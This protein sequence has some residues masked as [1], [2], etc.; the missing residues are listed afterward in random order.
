MRTQPPDPFW[1][2]VD[3]WSDPEACWRWIGPDTA[4]GYGVWRPGDGSH[5]A[6]RYAWEQLVG[7]VPDGLELHHK[8]ENPGC[9]NPHHLEP[10]THKEHQA[11]HP[12]KRPP[13]PGP[14]FAAHGIEFMGVTDIQREFRVSRQAVVMWRQRPD[15][16][17]PVAQ[18]N[19]GRNPIYDAKTVRAWRAERGQINLD[20]NG[21]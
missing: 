14:Q 15:F 13:P 20:T 3:R 12:F 21:G 18:I 17:A 9:V 5:R 10:L 16:P 4:P 6:H 8:C 7:P 19:N 1:E 11:R 2:N